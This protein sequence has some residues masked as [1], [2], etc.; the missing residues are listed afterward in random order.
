MMIYAIIIVII[1]IRSMTNTYRSTE[2]LNTADWQRKCLEFGAR[3]T[4]D[5]SN[6]G[7]RKKKSERR[8]C[9]CSL[10]IFLFFFFKPSCY[11]FSFSRIILILFNFI[12]GTGRGEP[13]RT[14]TS[15]RWHESE[16]QGQ[17]PVSVVVLDHGSIEFVLRAAFYPSQ[18]RISHLLD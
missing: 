12:P 15:E 17:L 10:L 11:F 13:K 16:R 9:D 6:R 14:L 8:V 2:M 7:Q 5:S 18:G 4:E 3:T 1:I